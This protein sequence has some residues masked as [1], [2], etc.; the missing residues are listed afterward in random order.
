[1]T[2]AAG[3]PILP[4]MDLLS[5]LVIGLAFLFAF[6]AILR[7]VPKRRFLTLFL[8]LV[9]LA[10]FSYRWS[11]FRDARLEW[12]VGLATAILLLAV[13]WI[14]IGRKLPAPDDSNIRVWSEEDPFE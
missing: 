8:L 5:S 4:R 11:I 7:T 3:H 13:W 14:F 2:L 10:I 1:M 6:A 9:P 12:L